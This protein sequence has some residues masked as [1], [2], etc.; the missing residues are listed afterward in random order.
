M[1]RW[2]LEVFDSHGDRVLSDDDL[3]I[4]FWYSFTAT[5]AGNHF[6]PEPLER[7]PVVVSFAT[8]T[9]EYPPLAKFPYPWRHIVSGGLYTGVQT[10]VVAP[11]AFTYE[12]TRF[13]IF[14]KG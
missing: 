6:Y 9:D 10:Y 5:G 3:L 1:A 14:R 7:E 11:N 2:G 13:M 12:P 4:R 8:T